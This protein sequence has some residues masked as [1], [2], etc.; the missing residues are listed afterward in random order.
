[1]E[2]GHCLRS[3]TSLEHAD[4]RYSSIEAQSSAVDTEE[5]D[6]LFCFILFFSWACL[7]ILKGGRWPSFLKAVTLL[8]SV[9]SISVL[10]VVVVKASQPVWS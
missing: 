10:A 7:D 1:M 2:K 3:E 9:Q 5:P 6:F 4:K 8:L